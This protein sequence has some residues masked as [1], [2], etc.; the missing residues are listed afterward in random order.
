MPSVVAGVLLLNPSAVGQADF[1]KADCC[2]RRIDRSR[3]AL[4]DEL[5]QH[6]DVVIVRMGDNDRIEVMW[7]KRERR[8]VSL[9]ELL[10]ALE[11]TAIYKD[12]PSIDVQ[13][14]FRSG[15]RPGCAMER[16][17]LRHLTSM[18]QGTMA[19]CRT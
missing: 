9:A 12:F 2:W 4:S 18:P 13:Q 11:Q 7:R 17:R 6:A 19:M 8:P 14:V 1:A 3:V 10:W 16:D 15:D 5:G